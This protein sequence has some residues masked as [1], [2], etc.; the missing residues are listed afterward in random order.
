MAHTL[1][2]KQSKQSCLFPSKSSALFHSPR[3][4]LSAITT[5]KC[6]RP[7]KTCSAQEQLPIWPHTHPGIW[8]VASFCRTSPPSRNLSQLEKSIIFHL[9]DVLRS[10][11]TN[12]AMETL[13][14]TKKEH[15]MCIYTKIIYIYVYTVNKNKNI[16]ICV[17]MWN[18]V[19]TNR[20]N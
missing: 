20:W 4:L 11:T 2:F 13:I 17:R 12:M 18:Q 5:K 1:S 3:K 14:N 15:E 10:L 7:W 16:S 8:E 19:H 9:N 6:F